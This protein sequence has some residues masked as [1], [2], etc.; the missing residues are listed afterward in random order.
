MQNKRIH[1]TLL[2]RFTENDYLC[3][4]I[5]EQDGV[6]WQEGNKNESTTFYI[7]CWAQ[8][9]D[10]YKEFR[11]DKLWKTIREIQ[12]WDPHKL[13]AAMVLN[14]VDFVLHESMA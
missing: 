1:M 12:N 5:N 3:D 2:M 7:W 14:E 10:S 9:I 11:W 4:D 8:I 6:F 13:I